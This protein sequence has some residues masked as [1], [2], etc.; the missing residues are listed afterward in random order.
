[1]NRIALAVA[2]LALALA[3][4]AAANVRYASPAGTESQCSVAAPCSLNTAVGG[5]V[6][7]DEIV[8]GSGAYALTAAL[9]PS[10][11]LTIHGAPGVARPRIS[12]PVGSPVLE[13][14]VT[15]HISD[16][17]LES[18]NA[19]GTFLATASL[20]GDNSSADRI[21]SIATST[22][23]SATALRPGAGFILRDSLLRAHGAAAGTAALF[24]QAVAATS[25]VTIRNVTAI[26]SAPADSTALS[27]FG[28]A[29][30]PNSSIEGTNVIADAGVDATASAAPGIASAI[31]LSNSNFNSSSG[32]VTGSGNQALLPVFVNAAAGDFRQAAGS[33]TIDAGL[34]DPANGALD[35]DGNA[36]TVN[37]K[38]D[39]GAYELVPPDTVAPAF[40]AASI[41][42]RVFAV[43]RKG[44]AEKPAAARAA[45]KGTTF[46]YRLSEAARVVFTIQRAQPGRRVGSRCAKQRRSNLKRRKCTRYRLFG[47]FA[48]GAGAGTNSKRWSGRI[49]RR[50]L[51]SG[52]YRAT[53][54][55]TDGVG[56]HSRPK[57][58]RFRVVRR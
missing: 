32:T 53:L 14:L 24:F 46:K 20:L 18:T 16:L 6:G 3:P 47:R 44:R 13:S 51:S 27:I 2:V 43:D 41:T 45:K 40:R 21:E 1:M 52:R 25:T 58:L 12:A 37:G 19:G 31:H 26:A 38:T 56:N 11:P 48:Q 35:L 17:T 33:P 30:G 4:S 34:T 57:R 8:V 50:G 39:V 55:A 49:A 28:T 36:R 29:G 15:L 7:S 5:A 10:V 54:L 42:N 23:G 22:S 9:T